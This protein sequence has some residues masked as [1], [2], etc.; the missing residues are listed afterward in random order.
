MEMQTN[1]SVRLTA[2][3]IAHHLHQVL[4]Q[5]KQSPILSVNASEILDP[6]EEDFAA[7]IEPDQPELNAGEIAFYKFGGKYIVILGHEKARRAL[8][9]GE[10]VLRGKLISKQALKRCRIDSGA[11]MVAK[12]VQIETKR[13]IQTDFRDT[14]RS[15]DKSLLRPAAVESNTNNKNVSPPSTVK[16]ADSEYKPGSSAVLSVKHLPDTAEDK[17]LINGGQEVDRTARPYQAPVVTAVQA[18]P[19]TPA[20]DTML[21]A[22]QQERV[23]KAKEQHAKD[24][25]AGLVNFAPADWR[26]QHAAKYGRF[27]GSPNVKPNPDKKF[28]RDRTPLSVAEVGGYSNKPRADLAGRSRLNGNPLLG[29]DLG[30]LMADKHQSE[31]EPGQ[32]Q[33]MQ[34]FAMVDR[35]VQE[36][37]GR[38]SKPSAPE[39]TGL[40]GARP[41][42][43]TH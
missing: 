6:R 38:R 25:A 12:P 23:R 36:V 14:L 37:A 26:E 18:Q 35:V 2:V 34:E 10:G 16:V 29:K 5:A 13:P 15:I 9:S 21:T 43:S 19:A 30:Q 7:K 31:V 17:V 3:G 20:A 40:Y 32:D 1:S 33:P 22:D 24:M 4:V 27:P 11:P 42:R 41:R 28:Y 39:R 8:E